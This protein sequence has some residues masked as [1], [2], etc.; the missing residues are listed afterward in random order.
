VPTVAERNMCK[1]FAAQFIRCKCTEVRGFILPCAAGF[2][3]AN[4]SCKANNTELVG[5]FD[6]AHVRRRFCPI[7]F[8]R[9]DNG[10]R[11]HYDILVQ[12]TID[13]G[14]AAGWPSIEI[15]RAYQNIRNAEG[16]ILELDKS[17]FRW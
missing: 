13:A 17:L 6:E 7:C 11:N 9:M 10:I 16:E 8:D 14:K 2:S 4:Q 15:I 5:P 12:Q 1:V 3:D